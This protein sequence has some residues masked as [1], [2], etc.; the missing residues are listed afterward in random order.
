MISVSLSLYFVTHF[1]LLAGVNIVTAV[2]LPL[3][4]C[5]S[6]SGYMHAYIWPEILGLGITVYCLYQS[7]CLS[8]TKSLSGNVK[9]FFSYLLTPLTKH[10]AS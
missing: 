8:R 10:P 7:Y 2:V 1:F 5:T 9:Y 3:S 4:I 6:Y